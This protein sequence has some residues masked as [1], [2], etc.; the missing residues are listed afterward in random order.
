MINFVYNLCPKRSFEKLKNLIKIGFDDVDHPLLNAVK[1]DTLKVIN[2][3]VVFG[4]NSYM[5]RLQ[6]D[7]YF[8]S[9]SEVSMQ[10]GD[11]GFIDTCNSVCH[12]MTHVCQ[13]VTGSLMDSPTGDVVFAFNNK[14]YS[15]T[16]EEVNHI[17]DND[18]ML[19]HLLPYEIEAQEIAGSFF[20]SDVKRS[21]LI[22]F[23]RNNPAA[24]YS[25]SEADG[26]NMAV[27]SRMYDNTPHDSMFISNFPRYERLWVSDLNE[28]FTGE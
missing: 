6:D 2:V 1:N 8:V 27:V 15:F 9:I 5:C 11:R 4:M 10:L 19:G 21:E 17:Q 14:M 26:V 28:L 18:D 7:K 13:Y 22:E 20:D 16:Q 25:I 3:H 24:A 12:E 23:M